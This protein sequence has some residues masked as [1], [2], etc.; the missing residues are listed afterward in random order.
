MYIIYMH[1]YIHTYFI[2][3]CLYLCICSSTLK[4]HNCNFFVNILIE[5]EVI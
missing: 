5:S 1:T 2:Y 3:V 4:L